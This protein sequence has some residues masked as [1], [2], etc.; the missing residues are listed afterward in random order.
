MALALLLVNPNI[1]WQVQ[2]NFPVFHHLKELSDTQLV[3]VNR[4]D[5][6]KEQ[7]LFFIG[8]FFIVL[9]AFISFFTYPPFKKFRFFKFKRRVYK[10]FF[11]SGLLC[12]LNNIFSAEK[13]QVCFIKH[14][15]FL[16]LKRVCEYYF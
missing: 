2:N 8:S 5:F 10:I 7:L 15:L 16:I 13:S 14:S 1:I 6:L 11:E 9:S 4:A 12:Q 3:N